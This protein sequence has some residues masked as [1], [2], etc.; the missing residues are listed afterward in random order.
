ML[1][2][3]ASASSQNPS[4]IPLEN[5]K[6]DMCETL[7]GFCWVYDECT[8]RFLGICTKKESRLLKIEA[9][10]K[11]KEEAKQLFDMNFILQVREKPL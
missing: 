9:D 5:R 6:Y 2:S 3:C 11:N 1:S 10:F 8:K 7:D 4:S